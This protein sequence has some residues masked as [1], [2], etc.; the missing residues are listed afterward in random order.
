MYDDLKVDIDI[1]PEITE[2]DRNIL[3]QSRSGFQTKD[4]DCEMTNVYITKDESLNFKHSFTG[5]SFLPYKLQIEKF[6]Y[7]EVPKNERPYP[8][9]EEGSFKALAGCLR[10]TNIRLEDIN[11][12]GTFSFYDY[13]Q[14]PGGAFRKPI[15]KWYQ[16]IGETKSG[17]IISLK[18]LTEEK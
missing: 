18:R 14:I 16:F 10:K 15:T 4:F 8:D 3:R 13:I 1:L 6:E 12:T 5:D 17:K 2:E 11:Y 7:E 9:A